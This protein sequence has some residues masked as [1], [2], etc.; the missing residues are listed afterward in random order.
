M[1]KLILMLFVAAAFTACNEPSGD[2]A[3][4]DTGKDVHSNQP[5]EQTTGT[6][7]DTAAMHTDTTAH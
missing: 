5:A 4:N 7:A 2:D 1:K 3:G 6:S